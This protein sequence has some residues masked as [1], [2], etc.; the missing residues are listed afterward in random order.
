MK[1]LALF[2]AGLT[3]LCAQV[4]PGQVFATIPSDQGEVAV[5]LA[6]KDRVLLEN[7]G[8]TT[9]LSP[10]DAL[11][12]AHWIKEDRTA[13]YQKGPIA[14][15]REENAFLLEITTEGTKTALRL[16]KE[17]GYQLAGALAAARAP[18]ANP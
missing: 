2:L 7:R 8:R 3:S 14:L 1:R 10:E 15:R 12:V 18:S 4:E 17:G 6:S 9:T 5:S 11:A 13:S 16:S